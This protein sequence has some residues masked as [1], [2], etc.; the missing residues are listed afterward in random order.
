MT[1]RTREPAAGALSAPE[2]ADDLVSVVVP[3]RNEERALGATLTA[4]RSQDHRNLQI[5]VVDGGST[6]ST[7]E[8]IRRHMAE[9]PRI[10]L[11]HNPH[12]TIPTALNLGL[13]HARGRW[14]VRMDAHSTVDPGYVRAGRAGAAGG[15]VGR[16]GRTQGRHRDDTRRPGHRGGA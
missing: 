10:E 7:V 16:G 4:L 1:L 8:V 9:D 13:A 3:A 5:V 2:A 6:D 11:V 12:R 14:L 15:P